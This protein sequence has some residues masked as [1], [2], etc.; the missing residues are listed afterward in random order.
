MPMQ[1]VLIELEELI[2]ERKT[3]APKDS[4]VAKMLNGPRQE[5]YRK[6]PEEAVEVVLACT[7]EGDLAQELADLWFHSLLVMG[8]HDVS[9]A[10]V[11]GILRNRRCKAAK[12]AS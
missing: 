12:E 7:D 11:S 4:Y 10:E 3:D 9:V 6:V 5:L 1:D 8:K 2:A